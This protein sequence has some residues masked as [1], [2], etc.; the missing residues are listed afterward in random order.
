MVDE[1][2][3]EQEI[4]YKETC[5]RLQ[6]LLD[7]A[8]DHISRLDKEIT[9]LQSSI[10][11]FKATGWNEERAVKLRRLETFYSRFHAIMNLVISKGLSMDIV[12]R[13][14]D[15][16]KEELAYLPERPWD[17]IFL[18]EKSKA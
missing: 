3:A 12:H 7:E 9:F 1:K 14:N 2:V 5:E 16:A 15:L 6:E 17:D 4:D 11:K 8:V 10:S 18:F 13:L